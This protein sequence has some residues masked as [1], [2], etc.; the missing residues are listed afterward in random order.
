MELVQYLEK[1][2]VYRQG[3]S[4]CMFLQPAITAG[5]QLLV[6]V[7]SDVSIFLAVAPDQTSLGHN[8]SHQGWPDLTPPYLLWGWLNVEASTVGKMV[9]DCVCCHTW[10]RSE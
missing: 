4:V 10:I 3:E 1:S 5:L 6:S 9:V 8:C 7:S 2:P